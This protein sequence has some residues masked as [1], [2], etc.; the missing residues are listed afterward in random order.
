MWDVKISKLYIYSTP[1]SEAASHL[2]KMTSRRDK[3]RVKSN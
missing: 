3:Q 1:I 2:L